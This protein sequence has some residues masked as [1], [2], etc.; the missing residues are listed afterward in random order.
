MAFGFVHG[1][2]LMYINRFGNIRHATYWQRI[3]DR[4]RGFIEFVNVRV[5]FDIVSAYL[6]CHYIEYVDNFG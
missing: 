6:A 2:K 5:T 4:F 3:K 1:G